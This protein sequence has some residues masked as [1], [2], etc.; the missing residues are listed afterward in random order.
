M[1]RL[2][3]STDVSIHSLVRFANHLS[4]PS[5]SGNQIEFPSVAK[6]LSV[7]ICEIVICGKKHQFPFVHCAPFCG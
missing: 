6:V 5:N 2:R 4:A 1:A 7:P 3:Q